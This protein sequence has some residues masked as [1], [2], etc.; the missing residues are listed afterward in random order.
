MDLKI[1]HVVYSNFPYSNFS[2]REQGTSSL[3]S[4][5]GEIRFLLYFELGATGFGIVRETIARWKN[6]FSVQVRKSFLYFSKIVDKNIR[7]AMK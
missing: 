5:K 4:Q 1:E 3:F 6:V 2:A 7:E